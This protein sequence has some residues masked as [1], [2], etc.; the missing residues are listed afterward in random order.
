MQHGETG[1]PMS[2]LGQKATTRRTSTAR[3]LIPRNRTSLGGSPM[4][5]LGH[6]RTFRDVHAT[7][8]GA[9][10]RESE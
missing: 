2:Q 10:V 1:L 4:S 9:R 8:V 7:S 5:V 6:Q 3:P